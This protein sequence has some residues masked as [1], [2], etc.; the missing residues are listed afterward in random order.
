MTSADFCQFNRTLL[1]GLLLWEFNPSRRR[2]SG[3][4]PRVRTMT[5][6]PSTRCIYCMGFGQYRTSFCLA[7]S[8]APRRLRCSFC[9]SSWDFALSFF[10]IPPHDGH[11]CSWLI[12]PA[13]KSIVVFHHLAIVHAAHTKKPSRLGGFRVSFA[14]I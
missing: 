13:A 3:R 1:Y 6:I 12:V 11:P 5:F 4:P 10:Q 2:H 8:S 14:K 9:S 7:N